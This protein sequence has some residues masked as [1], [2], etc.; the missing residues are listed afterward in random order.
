MAL[1]WAADLD[2]PA[3]AMLGFGMLYRLLMS[4]PP[5][6]GALSPLPRVTELTRAQLVKEIDEKG[7]HEF[8]RGA[9]AELEQCNP[10]LLQAAHHFASGLGEYLQAMQGLVLL[11]RAL[12]VQS[13]EERARPH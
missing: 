7:P 3:R 9:V 13:R 4:A 2:D 1:K 12:V 10:E 6:T 8:T 11:H 5:G